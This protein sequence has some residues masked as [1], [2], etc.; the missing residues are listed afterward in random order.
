MQELF[1]DISERTR[2]DCL[3]I[4]SIVARTDDI[5][6]GVKILESYRN[7]LTAREQEYMD[8][9]FHT[10]MEEHGIHESIID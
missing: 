3:A 9:A 10:W 8:F 6:K 7:T 2:K 5:L 4:F 1:E